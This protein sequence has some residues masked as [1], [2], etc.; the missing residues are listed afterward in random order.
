MTAL[1]GCHSGFFISASHF[2]QR[3]AAVTS[4]SSF[5]NFCPRTF[6]TAFRSSSPILLIPICA[7]PPGRLSKPFSS[8]FRASCISVL[9]LLSLITRVWLSDSIASSSSILSCSSSLSSLI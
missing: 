3:M 4:A 6:E 5:D 1:K 8:S 9:L 2:E 7:R